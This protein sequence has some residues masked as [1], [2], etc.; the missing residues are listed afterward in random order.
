MWP[1]VCLPSRS[2][3]PASEWAPQS[4]SAPSARWRGWF[5]SWWRCLSS[6]GC[7]FIFSMSPLSPAPSSLRRPRKAPSTLW[8]CSATPTAAP[9]Q[10]CTPSYRT[11]SRRAFRTSCASRR[12]QAL[13][14]WRG[15]TAGQTEAGWLMTQP[16]STLAWRFTM[17]LSWM[18]SFRP[19]SEIRSLALV[20][21]G[22]QEKE[23]G[24]WRFFKTV[25]CPCTTGDPCSRCRVGR[26]RKRLLSI[27]DTQ[28]KSK[29]KVNK[30]S[31][32]FHS[33]WKVHF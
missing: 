15:A 13:M 24:A 10:S 19:A 31:R 22:R 11:T 17:P 7:P 14:R 29:C 25:S 1:T 16:S 8:W 32:G 33:S 9:T 2:S 26:W 12:W 3:H 6:V 30:L 28:T 18:A 21:S 5:P 27:Y 20:H 4:A 23:A